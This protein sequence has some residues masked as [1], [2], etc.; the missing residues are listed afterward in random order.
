MRLFPLPFFSRTCPSPSS[1]AVKERFLETLIKLRGKNERSTI[2]LSL[3]LVLLLSL[4]LPLPADYTSSLCRATQKKS[5]LTMS[6]KKCAAAV[7]ARRKESPK[8]GKFNTWV[9]AA[10]GGADKT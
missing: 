9:A 10:A 5:S 8:A 4:P 6:D 7:A 3:S 1:K 2:S